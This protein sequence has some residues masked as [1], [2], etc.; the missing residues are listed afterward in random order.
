LGAKDVLG[1]IRVLEEGVPFRTLERFRKE[2]CLTW[3]AIAKVLRIPRRTLAR[4]KA[5]GILTSSESER[6]V[7]L[8]QL[9]DR[10]VDLFEGN[11][12]AAR[13]W[14]D[15]PN[16]ALGQLPPLVLA[17]TEIGARAVEDL[18]GRLAHGVYS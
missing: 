10:A 6:F 18:I 15:S 9:Y 12:G 11:A 13:D 14:L 17:E 3:D 4:R 2:S 1:L 7:R 5:V 16:K 8:A